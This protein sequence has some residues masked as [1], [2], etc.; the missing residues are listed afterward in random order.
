MTEESS[1][2]VDQNSKK[3]IA[4]HLHVEFDDGTCK[5]ISRDEGKMR[6][7]GYTAFYRET[8]SHIMSERGQREHLYKERTLVWSKKEP[9]VEPEKRE[10]KPISSE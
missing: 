10:V 5:T 2:T 1:I 6:A 9:W 3:V 7:E 8:E 4:F